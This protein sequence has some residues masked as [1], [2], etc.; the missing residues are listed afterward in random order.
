VDAAAELDAAGADRWEARMLLGQAELASAP[1]VDTK[2]RTSQGNLAIRRNAP[3][4]E[5]KWPAG[6]TAENSN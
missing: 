1:V 2:S 3:N 6:K 5:R 4:A